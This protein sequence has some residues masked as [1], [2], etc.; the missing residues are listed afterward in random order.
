V[1][2]EQQVLDRDGLV[3]AEL[4]ADLRDLLGGGVLA[5]KGHGRVGRRQDEED[6]EGDARDH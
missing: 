5:G 1:L 3:E 4:V 2:D 6:Q